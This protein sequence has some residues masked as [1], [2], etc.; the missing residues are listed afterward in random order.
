MRVCEGVSVSDGCG[1][2]RC[3]NY[4]N[5]IPR[6]QLVWNTFLWPLTN[7]V[8]LQCQKGE[9]DD[10]ANANPNANPNGNGNPQ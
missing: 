8:T 2:P 10:N 3:R 6:K 5:S 1:F 4:W 9:A 7:S